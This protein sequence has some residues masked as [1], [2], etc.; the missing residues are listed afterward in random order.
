ML[1]PAAEPFGNRGIG[2]LQSRR[3][4]TGGRAAAAAL[5][6]HSNTVS[7]AIARAGLLDSGMCAVRGF[8]IAQNYDLGR[9]VEGL[10]GML[11]DVVVMV[12][13]ALVPVFV[14]LDPEVAVD[15]DIAR[16]RRT[17]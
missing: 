8:E 15:V 9:Q 3:F 6:M 17:A 11:V 16:A 2:R 5:D 13:Y 1:F 12:V 7:T 4:E 10:V 14:V